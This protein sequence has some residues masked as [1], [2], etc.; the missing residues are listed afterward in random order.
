MINT[1]F[2]R[3]DT[4]GD[5]RWLQ[6]HMF[7]ALEPAETAF[8][9]LGD[10][11]INTGKEPRDSDVKRTIA[12]TGFNIYCV[13][14]NHEIRPSDVPGI[15]LEWDP[16]V[17]GNVYVESAY[18]T[19]KYFQD[20]G[21][22]YI[23]TDKR[24]YRTLILSGAYSVDK[25]WRLKNKYF[26]Y[27]REQLSKEEMADVERLLKETSSDFDFVLAHTCPMSM[28]PI[29]K[30][31][32]MVDQSTVDNTMEEWLEKIQHSINF[33]VFCSGHYHSDRFV[34][35]HHFLYFNTIDLLDDVYNWS[36]TMGDNIK[37]VDRY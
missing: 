7:K 24:E 23:K 22:Y 8:I 13:R 35:A 29:D 17:Q 34:D 32:P 1:W 15:K 10:C 2:I 3:G 4:H 18:P 33:R 25:Y 28:R 6:Q 36:N 11:G 9:I 20:Y 26:W 12:Q 14:G 16:Y 37:N 30:F 21:I 31:L 27:A 19:I 5:F